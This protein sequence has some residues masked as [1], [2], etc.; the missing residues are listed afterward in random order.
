MNPGLLIPHP[1]SHHTKLPPL[2]YSVL[3]FAKDSLTG[4]MEVVTFE[5]GSWCLR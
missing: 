5:L 4:F 2:V 1:T 3:I